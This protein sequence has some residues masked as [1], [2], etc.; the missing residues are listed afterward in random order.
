MIIWISRYFDINE[1]GGDD[2]QAP[3]FAFY[4]NSQKADS[5]CFFNVPTLYLALGCLSEQRRPLLVCIL[6]YI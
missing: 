4:P 1:N 6:F 3:N 5:Q 2:F